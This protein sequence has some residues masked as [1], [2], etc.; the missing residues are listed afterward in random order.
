MENKLRMKKDSFYF[1]NL[2]E[3]A[4]ESYKAA[5]FL[6]SVVE[7]FDSNEIQDKLVKLHE[8]EQ[9]GDAKKHQM[10]AVL[11][12]AF[13]TPIEREDLVDL[14]D[15]LDDITDAIEEVLLQIYMCNITMIRVDVLPTIDLLLECVRALCTVLQEF[16]NFKSSAII[17]EH[18]VKVND[19]EEQGD[20]LY[21]ENMHLLHKEGDIREIA[22]WRP[23]YECI[24]NCFDT[25]EHTADIV[26]TV[27]MKNS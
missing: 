2:L 10:M 17:C 21:Q 9:N 22:A 24:E 1:D 16:R 18:I 19:L 5:S 14:S 8:M 25:C 12:K 7:E 27:I 13:I 23:I 26:Q 20:H 3:C 11:S 15:N 4:Q 6:K